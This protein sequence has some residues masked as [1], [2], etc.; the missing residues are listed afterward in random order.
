MAN[1]LYQ[2]EERHYFLGEIDYVVALTLGRKLSQ[3]RDTVPKIN[4]ATPLKFYYST[5]NKGNQSEQALPEPDYVSLA[6]CLFKGNLLIRTES[7]SM[8]QGR[9]TPI[10]FN[11]HEESASD[12][13]SMFDLASFRRTKK[14]SGSW[15]EGDL[16]FRI[17]SL[18]RISINPEL[19]YELGNYGRRL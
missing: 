14:T 15:P 18:P 13:V 3:L 16:L 1:Q 9:L 2:A 12:P 6:D 5:E 4:S 10:M 11:D 17:D 19:L 8:V 7:Y